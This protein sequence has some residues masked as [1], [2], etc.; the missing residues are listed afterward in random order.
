M[1]KYQE[2]YWP[3]VFLI[4]GSN[5]F[6]ILGGLFQID[7]LARE[8]RNINVMMSVSKLLITLIWLYVIQMDSVAFIWAALIAQ[9]M[10]II[11]MAKR[12]NLGILIPQGKYRKDTMSFFHTFLRYGFPLIGWYIGTTVLNL[13]DR[14]MLDYF[15]T[16]REVG[17][18]SANFTIAVQAL[19]L[20][21]NPLFFAVQPLLLNEVEV[22]DDKKIMEGRV[23]YFTRIFILIAVPFG[24]Y[25][26]IYR[27]EVSTII[28]G[29]QFAQGSIIIPILVIGFFAWNLGLYGQLCCQVD[30]RT[31]HMFYF[32][33]V[34]AVANFVLNLFFTPKCGFIGASVSTTL[35]FFIYTALLYLSSFKHTRW[36]LPWNTLMKVAL[37]NTCFSF[38]FC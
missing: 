10:V 38:S 32:V 18:Y 36:I 15:R 3:S 4:I 1:M 37:A 26:S 22:N 34:A 33:V 17:I 28:L 27:N 31:N 23:S 21:C 20:V 11:P 29:E 9:V 25:F 7:L 16:S 24:A 13:T 19:A 2:Y 5:Y 12:L 35:G 14:Y 8:Y 30:K 6:S